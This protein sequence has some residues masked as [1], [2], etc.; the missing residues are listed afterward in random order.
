MVDHG[1]LWRACGHL[2]LFKWHPNQWGSF[3]ADLFVFIETFAQDL[4]FGIIN[5][6]LTWCAVIS[7]D[8]YYSLPCQS[9]AGEFSSVKQRNTIWLGWNLS[10]VLNIPGMVELFFLQGT[11]Q[12][13]TPKLAYSILTPI[14]KWISK[15]YLG[16]CW[17]FLP[18]LYP[19]LTQ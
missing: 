4:S 8:N 11:Q 14:R 12:H 10:L 16:E 7:T 1:V 6:F 2:C 17:G 5:Y 19:Q 13:N 3:K 9:L 18:H 15:G